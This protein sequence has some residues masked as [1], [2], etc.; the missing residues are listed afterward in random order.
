VGR[1]QTVDEARQQLLDVLREARLL[2]ALPENNFDWSTWGNVNAALR[3]VDGLITA[4]ESG[5]LPNRLAIS[6]L[7]APTGPIQ[8]VSIS[9]GWAD[10]FL[11]LA[12]RSDTALEAAYNS[13]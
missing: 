12:D 13:T 2:L 5:R 1:E 11:A 4:L 8:E 9:S 7:F 10:R 6:N 3:E